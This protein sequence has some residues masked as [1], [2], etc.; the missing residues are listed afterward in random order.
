MGWLQQIL[1]FGWRCRPLGLPVM[2]GGKMLGA[3]SIDI[4]ADTPS[5]LMASGTYVSEQV[6]LADP[7]L[8]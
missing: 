6:V 1:A 8:A 7:M 4:D 3:L 5:L 2:D